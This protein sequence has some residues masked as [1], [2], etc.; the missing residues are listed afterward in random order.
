MMKTSTSEIIKPSLRGH[1]HQAAFF[2]A[3]GA[4]SM[5]LSIAQGLT[6]I[7]VTIV[8]SISLIGLFGISALYHRPTWK[9]EQRIWMKRLDHAAIYLLIAGTTTPICVLSLPGAAG[10]NLLRLVWLSAIFGI[11]QSLFWVKAPKWV[12]AGLYITVG[13]LAVPFIPEFSST[14]SVVNLVF[15]ILGGVVYIIG[16]VIYALKKPNPLP[17]YFGYHEIFH[18]LVIIAAFFHFLIIASLIH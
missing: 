7:L 8:Y 4:C 11:F 5:L 2:F 9:P 14:L 18:L 3:L 10:V 16:A 6:S 13:C 1:F 12:S 15:L 17:K